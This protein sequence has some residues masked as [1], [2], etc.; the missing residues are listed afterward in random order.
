MYIHLLVSSLGGGGIFVLCSKYIRK[1]R[2]WKTFETNEWKFAKGSYNNCQVKTTLDIWMNTKEKWQKIFLVIDHYRT[3]DI[4]ECIIN[5]WMLP[6]TIL[7]SDCMAA[8]GALWDEMHTRI[9]V[10]HSMTFA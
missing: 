3:S 7:K 6:G 10:R 4:L 9:T 1:I 5:Q 8:Y 2:R